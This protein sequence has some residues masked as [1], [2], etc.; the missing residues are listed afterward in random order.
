MLE[1]RVLGATLKSLV[2]RATRFLGFVHSCVHL[3]QTSLT[4]SA[5]T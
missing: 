1:I 2:A 3:L 5:L 4:A